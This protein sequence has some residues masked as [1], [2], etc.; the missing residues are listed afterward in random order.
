MEEVSGLDG[1][2]ARPVTGLANLK[3]H[4]SH[5]THV[6]VQTVFPTTSDHNINQKKK[7]QNKKKKKTKL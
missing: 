4:Q 7:R 1:I 5:R 2:P 6:L 3:T